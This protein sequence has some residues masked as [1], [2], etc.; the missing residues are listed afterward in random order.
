[1][2]EFEIIPYS[3]GLKEEW[4][5]FVDRSKNATFL[6][7][8]DYMDYHADRFA[9]SSLIMRR[10][11]K[12]YALLPASVSGD[13]VFSHGGLTYGGMLTDRKATGAEILRLF[14]KM[15]R[16]LA[17]R[18]ASF[19]IYKPVPHIYHRLPAEEDLY[20]LFRVG[21][22]LEARLLSCS[23]LQAERLRFRDIR[24]SGIRKARRLGITIERSADYPSFWQILEDNLQ[25]RYGAS[26][27]HTLEEMTR[28]AALF[29]CN[30]SLHAAFLEGRM[31]AGTVI[32]SSRNVAHTQY[33]SA[34]PEGKHSG[35][36]DLLFDSLI[37][38]EYASM[39]YFDFGTSNGDGGRWLNETL[40]YQ[41][42][43][44]GGRAICYD[45]Y[46]IDLAATA[47]INDRHD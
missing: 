33:I 20:A 46:R 35:A 36:L 34:S 7:K 39:K 31:L 30:I 1:M 22:T 14:R 13:T 26:P 25:S 24:K 11:G 3:S 38:R 6:F 32:Y 28:L 17:A 42:E 45:T 5:A 4:D 21:A 23:V 44:F 40:L 29:P 37:N 10:D 15:C 8:R 16:F 18:G 12:T 27:V 43:G 9:D 19:L 41:K 47:N 2:P